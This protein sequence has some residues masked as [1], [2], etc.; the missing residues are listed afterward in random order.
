MDLPK[1]KNIIESKWMYKIKFKDN[2]EVERFKTRLVA[3][4]Y[5]QKAGLD[6]HETFSLVAKIATTR[7]VI[8]VTSYKGWKMY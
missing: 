2:R 7:L 5:S 3:K 1:G 8:T 6:Y 4:R